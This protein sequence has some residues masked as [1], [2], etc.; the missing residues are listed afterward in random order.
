MGAVA[1]L[2]V[3]LALVAA[4]GLP[5]AARA[6]ESPSHL[7]DRGPGIPMSIFGTYVRPGEL[8]VYPFVEWYV[9]SN[10]E[11]KPS[12]FGFGLDLD[13]RG[14]YRASEQLLYLAYGVSD[15]LAV[16]MEGAIIQAHLDKSPIDP[17]AM[18]ARFEESG[19]GDVEGQIRWR[20]MEE[21]ARR[22]EGFAYFETVL[23]LQK[24]R[25]L[26]GTQDWEF[27]LGAGLVRGHRWGTVTVRAAVE[28]AREE[29]KLD[30]GEYAV[31]YLKRLS[32]KW[33]VVGIVEGSQLDEVE[34]IT[35]GQWHFGQR[36]WL[37][38]NTS[39]GLTEN[40]TGFAPEVGVMF[41]F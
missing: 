39:F 40:A 15:R 33:R 10:L 23:P 19:V 25:R 22:P 13:Y 2:A 12:E 17:T 3:T 21:A 37:K 24:N 6:Q 34:L 20:W 26:I 4:L 38:L 29:G 11:Y 28:Y 9:D 31:E 16:E 30:V 32:P 8:L 36:A 14:K 5:R 7:A 1:R 35:E 27:A 41:S 18:P